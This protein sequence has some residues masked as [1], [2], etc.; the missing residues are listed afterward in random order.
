MT[1]AALS[2][3]LVLVFLAVACK[4][5]PATPDAPRP[6][7]I[8]TAEF[9]NPEGQEIK[10]DFDKSRLSIDGKRLNPCGKGKLVVGAIGTERWCTLGDGVRHGLYKS[11][12]KNGIY[13]IAGQYRAGRRHGTWRYWTATAV[14]FAVETYE[15]GKRVRAELHAGGAVTAVEAD[16]PF[17]KSWWLDGDAACP[18]GTTF[19]G[20]APP[21]GT[22]AYCHRGDGSKHGPFCRWWKADGKE[23]ITEGTYKD[24][25]TDG[26]YVIWSSSGTKIEV[27]TMALGKLH[28][29]FRTFF[30]D[31]KKRDVGRFKDGQRT[32]RWVTYRPGG[33]VESSTVY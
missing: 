9:T 6:Q 16:L 3:G 20:T 33:K 27:G 12:H 21:A 1:K 26:A 13:S 15:D 11:T 4:K 5:S 24:G 29:A 25:I 30:D 31:G 23:K 10:V 7:K 19:A 22:L 2:S 8:V 14:L 28:G 32:G 17:L 18:P